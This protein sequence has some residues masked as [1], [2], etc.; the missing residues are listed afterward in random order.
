MV[1]EYVEATLTSSQDQTGITTKLKK[2]HPELQT[3]Q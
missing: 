2:N 3:E 1:A